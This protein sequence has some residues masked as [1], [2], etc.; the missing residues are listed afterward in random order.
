MRNPGCHGSYSPRARIALAIL[1]GFGIPNR[2]A[3]WRH[4]SRS[5]VYFAHSSLLWPALICLLL[6]A[7]ALG[8]LTPPTI[9]TTRPLGAA[10]GETIS[11]ELGGT[12]LDAAT[13]LQFDDSRVRVDAIK[14]EKTKLTSK[15]SIPPD[16]PPG[17]LHFRL[18][19]PKG[20]SNEGQLLVGRA[21]KTIAEIE[22]NNG[23]RKPQAIDG[24]T[25]IEGK[26]EPGDD[27]DVFSVNMKAGE[28]LVAEAIAARAGSGLDALI[29]V[30]GPDGREMAAE[31]DTFG[32]D[33]AVAVRAKAGGR[34]FVQVQDANGRNRDNNIEQ[35]VTRP[36]RLEVGA[37][38]LVTSSF[39]AG[40]TRGGSTSLRLTGA[41]LNAETFPLQL[42]DDAPLGDRIMGFGGSNG[43]LLRVDDRSAEEVEPNDDAAAKIQTITVP[44]AINGRFDRRKAR[45]GDVDVFRLVAAPGSEGT[46]RISAIAAR[47]GSPADPVI[48][49][50]DESHETQAENDDT[51]GR[52]ARLERPIDAKTGLLVAVRDYHGRGGV[53][54]VYRL[55]VEPIAA[56]AI[57]VSADLGARV[58][59]RGGRVGFVVNVERRGYD[60]PL[61]VLAGE[62]PEGVAVMPVTL[63]KGINAAFLIVSARD[64][65]PIG[66][67]PFRL[68]VRDAPAPAEFAYRER[69]A[70]PANADGW[71]AVAEPSSLGVRP[72]SDELIVAAGEKG[73]VKLA[74]DRR[75]EAAKKSAVKV[76]LVATEGTLEGFEPVAEQTVAADS[77]AASFELKAR[78]GA[79]AQ[80]KWVTAVAR[81]ENAA[82]AMAVV[83]APFRVVVS[84][85]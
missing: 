56:K 50:L 20:P 8:Q 35:K 39:P 2:V 15:V 57:G 66:R 53:R 73:T 65:A 22:P 24:P 64:D 28:W 67:F 5:G 59:P 17:P 46:F 47:V 25:A 62:T 40:A 21:I 69:G 11:L 44:C 1:H 60:G 63:P 41:N 42:P 23:F 85:R 10:P 74:L 4:D 31:D 43:I 34:Y 32:K 9:Q 79:P 81:F 33:A 83:S 37:I 12:E 70:A 7:P 82:E 77:S 68:T 19:G 16:T 30:F 36:Y 38:A 26:I 49:I 76:R 71:L 58:V 84:P 80:S 14:T 48:T 61:T 6:S 72:E 78:P 51:G 18:F 3:P 27:V 13:A 29:T 54:S 75:N 55:E 52:D 45:E